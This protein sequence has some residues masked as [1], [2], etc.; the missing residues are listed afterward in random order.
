MCRAVPFSVPGATEEP[1]SRKVRPYMKKSVA[2]AVQGVGPT[3]C[4]AVPLSVP[5]AKEETASRK[6]RPYTK[7]P[8]HGPFRVIGWGHGDCAP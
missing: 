2:R 3:L 4:R 6:V 1:A 7:N 8:W 5:R